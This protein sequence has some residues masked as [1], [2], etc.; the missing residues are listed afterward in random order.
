MS[1]AESEPVAYRLSLLAAACRAI[2]QTAIADSIDSIRRLVEGQAELPDLELSGPSNQTSRCPRCLGLVEAPLDHVSSRGEP[3]CDH[4]ADLCAPD[5]M[6]AARA[7]RGG[8]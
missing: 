6:A 1:G 2:G 4:C 8:R 3:L 5:L 7:L